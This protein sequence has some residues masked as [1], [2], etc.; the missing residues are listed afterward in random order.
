MDLNGNTESVVEKYIDKMNGND[1][2]YLKLIKQ[3]S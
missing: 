1:F 2:G 3:M